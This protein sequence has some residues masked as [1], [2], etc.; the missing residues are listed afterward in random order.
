ML[1][2]ALD[3]KRA[4]KVLEQMSQDSIRALRNAADELRSAEIGRRE[5]LATVASF[6]RDQ[7]GSPFF[8]GDPRTRFDKML[9][10]AV[11]QRERVENRAAEQQESQ[12][13]AEAAEEANNEQE[14]NGSVITEKLEKSIQEAPKEDVAALL[15]EESVRCAAVILSVLP[16]DMSGELLNLLDD[17]KRE[18]IAQRLLTMGQVPEAIR[19]E[20]T[21][22]F[23]ERLREAQFGGS[24]TS[25]E[26]RL[27][28][29]ANM[30]SGLES[31]S[32][33]RVLEKMQERDPELAEQIERRIFAF[34]DLVHVERKSLQDLLG[35]VDAST[36]AIAIKGAPDEVEERILDNLSQRVLEQVNEER[37]LAGSVPVSDANEARDEIMQIAREMDREGALNYSS[38]AGEEEFVE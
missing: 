22:G 4:K 38:G 28:R 31:D 18:Q 7:R 16:G 9:N 26:E 15:N 34:K 32:Q 17:E 6:L 13:K 30:V 19:Q 3:E 27:D 8:V 14:D 24:A 36:I 11:E 20:V 1:V 37:E 10:E 23:Q 33:K 12:A 25:E 5:K 35:R 29:L 21:Q 2:S